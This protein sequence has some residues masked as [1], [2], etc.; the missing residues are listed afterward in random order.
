MREGSDEYLIGTHDGVYKTRSVKQKPDQ[1]K[2]DQKQ[3]LEVRGLPRRP[4]PDD[5]SNCDVLPAGTIIK[6]I[7]HDAPTDPIPIDPTAR[8][9]Y[10]KKHDIQRYG[11]MVGC[12]GCEAIKR[13]ATTSVRHSDQCRQRVE[14]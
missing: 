13:N 5:H 2:N 14:E 9:L 6:P 7:T 12:P 8:R 11:Y 1:E 4:T 3:L 10:I